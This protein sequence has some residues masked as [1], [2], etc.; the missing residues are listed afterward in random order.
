VACKRSYDA[1]LTVGG[2]GTGS[3]MELVKLLQGMSLRQQF[4]VHFNVRDLRAI[5]QIIV[6]RMHIGHV[7][8]PPKLLH[9]RLLAL[10]RSGVIR[11]S[12]KSF[13]SPERSGSMLQAID[14]LLVASPKTASIDDA[15]ENALPNAR[16]TAQRDTVSCG[17]DA[18]IFG[19]SWAGAKNHRV[20]QLH[21]D[22]KRFLRAVQTM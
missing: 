13:G 19:G 16:T 12:E 9:E 22:L 17:V 3:P 4:S 20:L 1:V 5:V 15:R 7:S 8:C 14:S 11:C 2:G 10:E 21:S 6:Q 18:V